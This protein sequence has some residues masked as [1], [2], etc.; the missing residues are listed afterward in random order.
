MKELKAHDLRCE[1]RTNPIGL[2]TVRPRLSWKLA[3]SG[4]GILQ[5]AYQ[6]QVDESADFL[7]PMWDSGK[8]ESDQSVHVEYGGVEP[9]PRTRYWYRVKVWDQA[10][11]ESAWSD[12]AYWE[13]ALGG[14]GEWRGVWI[15]PP[16]IDGKAGETPD[17]LRKA[18]NV[19]GQLAKARLY[20]TALGVYK[21]YVNGRQVDDS[22]LAPGWTSYRKRLQYQTYDIT[23]LVQPGGNAIGAILGNGWYM[24]Y[25]GWEGANRFYGEER[26]LLAQ[27]HLTYADGREELVATDGTWQCGRGGLL[28]SELYFGE[29]F[30]ARA[31]PEGWSTPRF[32]A[33]DWSRVS[34]PSY[35]MD[36]LAAQEN[37]PVRM[38][39]K[40]HPIAAFV[41]PRGEKVLDMGQNMVGWMRFR[42][43]ASPGC[44][45]TLRHAE[46][47]DEAGNFYTLNLRTALQEVRYICKGE[48]QESFEPLF[49]F[50]GF[51]YVAVEGWPSAEWSLES[52]GGIFEGCVIHTD[53]EQTG[54]F[55]CSDELLN[56]LQRNIVWG[57]R[58]NF[59]EIPTDCPQ[60]DERLGWTGDAQVF[61][62]TAAFQ[63]NVAP[64]FTKWLKDLA[65]D[66]LPDGGVP[67]VVPDLPFCGYNSSAW[68]DAAVICPWTLYQCYGDERMLRDQYPSMKAWVEYVYAQGDDRFLWN[69]GFHFGDWLALDGTDGRPIGSTPK[70]LI[71]TAYYA[72]STRLLAN[73][74]TALGF[75]DDARK[76]EDLHRNVVEAF[77]S[78]FV[79]PSGRIASPT[80]TAHVIALM[81]D[82]L[83]EADRPRAAQW[84]A[85]HIRDKQVHLTTGFVGTPYICHV[86]SRF[87]YHD[88]ACELVLQRE[89]PSWLYSVTK[90]ATTVWEHWDGIKPDGTMWSEEMNSFNHYA[91]GAVGDWLYRA[92]AGLDQEPE[93]PGYKRIRIR[94]RP[95]PGLTNAEAVYASMYGTI[96][97]YWSMGDTGILELDADIPPNT[98]ATI[99]LPDVRTDRITESGMSLESADGIRVLHASEAELRLEAGSGSYHFRAQLR[100]E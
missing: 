75:L 72:H 91:F 48:G 33:A 87:G 71:A 68:S 63:Y 43:T 57:Q 50:Q 3:A 67:H 69:T 21:L 38:I 52:V 19:Q 84:L 41:T 80:Q 6:I 61:I 97:S 49:S 92:L 85:A 83:A 51:R 16:N 24:G 44:T 74:A 5:S 55:S 89:Y 28:K 30:D 1:Y 29:W 37:E 18:F 26:A 62:R 88:L 34:L 39:E 58:G 25:L 36:R 32:E 70:D 98:T 86:L 13:M 99:I 96:R 100:S 93:V 8:V 73:A 7:E 94:P 54:R 66:Q 47:L 14:I 78:E 82:L 17:Y 23:H 53:M 60:R 10:D 4:R 95:G 90:G 79:T 76:Y 81:F 65:L 56:Q 35:D 64:F 40:L 20:A 15:T 59:L 11:R 31:E 2:E 9:K 45:I 42:V 22:L 77:R 12:A 27:L 46:V